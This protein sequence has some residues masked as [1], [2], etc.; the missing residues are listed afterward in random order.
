ML[1]Y[2]GYVSRGLV[3]E[4][5]DDA[6]MLN[7]SVI[8]EG[9]FEGQSEKDNGLFAV[10]DGVGSVINSE[11]ASRYALY[12]LEEC[13]PRNVDGIIDCINGA[14][15]RLTANGN[16]LSTTLCMAGVLE[17]HLISYNLGNSRLYRFRGGFLRRL[18]RD[19]S[20]V[21]ELLDM[22]VL[23][24]E[25]AKDFPEKN[26]I[27]RY[28]GSKRYSP[29]WITV[30]EHR[31]NFI[32]GDILMLCSDGVHDY[33]EIE[34]LEAVLSADAPLREK[35]CQIIECAHVAGGY[36]NETVILIDKI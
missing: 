8:H 22:G 24:E 32:N 23:N 9:I 7:H 10:A 26:V 11:L 33:I 20:K 12:C 2:V 21:Q 35:A 18:T 30:T 25:T 3:H 17:S 27:T 36:D 15:E 14:N 1:K 5:N 16:V 13:N 29:D 4:T 28:L 6:A 34:R 19:H 31:E